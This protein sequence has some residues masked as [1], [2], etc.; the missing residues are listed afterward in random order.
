MPSAMGLAQVPSTDAPE[1]AIQKIHHLQ[2]HPV[3]D[4]ALKGIYMERR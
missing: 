2:S 3:K 4:C 1:A